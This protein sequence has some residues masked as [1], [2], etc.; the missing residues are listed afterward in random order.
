MLKKRFKAA[1]GA[2]QKHVFHAGF[3]EV[4]KK[5]KTDYFLKNTFFENFEK[6]LQKIKEVKKLEKSGHYSYKN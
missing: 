1:A 2:P 4:I 3:K 6:I 5:Y